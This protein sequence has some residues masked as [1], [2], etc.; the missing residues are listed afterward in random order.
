V[1]V[2]TKFGTCRHDERV[3]IR[4]MRVVADHTIPGR[5]RAVHILVFDLIR[6]AH[7]AKGRSG[8]D[9]EL[10]LCRFVRVVAGGAHAVLHGRVHMGFLPEGRVAHI[11]EIGYLLH[12]LKSL[13]VL[14]RMGSFRSHVA[15]LTGIRGRMDR[16][17]LEHLSMA[18]PGHTAFL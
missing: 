13:L 3:V 15:A 6:M 5:S 4:F 14:L 18:L 12:K 11:A 1:A 16:L 10:G 9:K 17:G 8:L 7:L 2:E